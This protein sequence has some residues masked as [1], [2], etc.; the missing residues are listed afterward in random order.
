M[1]Q[2]LPIVGAAVGAYFGGPGGAQAG[3]MIGSI[4][5]NAVD[6]VVNRGPDIGDGQQTTSNEGAPRPRIWDTGCVGGNII[7]R[8]ELKKWI[9]KTRQGKG[10]GAVNKEE[11]F[12][13]TYAIRV[14]GHLIDG[15][16]R[17]WEDETLMYDVREDVSKRQVSDEDNEKYRAMFRLYRGTEDQMPDSELES[18][19]GVGNTPAF[20]GTSYIVFP[21]RN[22]TTRGGS[23][24]NYRFEI[25]SSG[26]ANFTEYPDVTGNN[27]HQ[28]YV[29]KKAEQEIEY[30]GMNGSFHVGPPMYYP[31]FSYDGQYVI[32]DLS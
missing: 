2:V 29:Y 12:S 8:G 28:L 11:Q 16:T 32:G 18:I 9:K 15:F 25:S 5:G 17:I 13:M 27:N 20:R 23:V 7:A 24:P 3:Y 14:A 1:R 19:F 31:D 6:P 10:G 21:N 30:K 26:D 4:V 22:L